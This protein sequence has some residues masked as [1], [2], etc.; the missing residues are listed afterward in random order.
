M[1]CK[2]SYSPENLVPAFK[3][4]KNPRHP[5]AEDFMLIILFEQLI[6]LLLSCCR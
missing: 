4:I 5:S 2:S 1:R 6:I 3:Q